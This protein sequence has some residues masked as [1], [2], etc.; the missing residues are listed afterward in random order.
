ML[1]GVKQ[2]SDGVKLGFPCG[3]ALLVI[4]FIGA[5]SG[6][7]LNVGPNEKYTL[8]SQAILAAAPG[9]TIRIAPGTYRDCV[10][11]TKDNLTVEGTGAGPVVSE[12]IC[13]GKGIF[14]I[15]APT[16]TIRNI[17][18]EG[19]AVDEGNGSGIRSEGANLTV[20][21]CT[22]RNN[23]DGILTTNMRGSLISIHNS[24]FVDNGACLPGKGC[25]HGVYIGF[26]DLVRIEGSHFVGSRTGHHVKSRARRT[27]L[28]NNTIEDGPD[29]TS[30]YLVDLPNGGSLLMTGNTLEKGPKTENPSAAISIG[31][32]GG[33]RPPGELIISGNTF[34]NDGPH[35]AFVRNMTTSNAQLTGNVVKGPVKL[36]TGPGSVD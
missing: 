31:E 26:V 17:T 21:N 24:T 13:Q 11:W 35:T 16:A 33:K 14:V 3:C 1:R 34:N 19:A 8:P 12:A 2:E 6:A 27:E 7:V 10:S 18:F 28:V 5:A 36:L 30:S 25:A 23:Q 29:G 32:E 4:S 9:D 22:F 15:A 20:E